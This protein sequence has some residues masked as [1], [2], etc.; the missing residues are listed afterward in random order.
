MVQLGQALTASDDPPVKA[1]H[2]Y[3]SNPAVVAPD[4]ARVIAGLEREDLFV[5][6]HEHLMTETAMYADII[7]PSTTF[8]ESTDLYRSYGHYYL[9]MARPVIEPVGETRSTLAIFNDLAARF[10]FTEDCFFET[11]EERIRNLLASDSPYLEGITLN[12][13]QE[14][15]P[16]IGRASCRE[17]V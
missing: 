1:L 4:S 14:G 2:V 15:R 12:V 9:Q 6:V 8:L 5:V 16:K 7:L 10:A 17:R 3:H 13:L 11:E